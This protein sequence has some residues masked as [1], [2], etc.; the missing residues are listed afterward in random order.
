[1]EKG[2]ESITVSSISDDADESWEW[3]DVRNIPR[4]YKFEPE[5]EELI[6]YYLKPKL[7]H[8]ELPPNFMHEIELYRPE[9]PDLD[10]LTGNFISLIYLLFLGLF[11]GL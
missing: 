1:M 10:T 4:G 7:E 11:L 8:K 6:T 3:E 2:K 5:D 9:C